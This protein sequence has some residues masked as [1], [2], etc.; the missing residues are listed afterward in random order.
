[1]TAQGHDIAH[2][3]SCIPAS[4]THPLRRLWPANSRG[5]KPAIVDR[6]WMIRLTVIGSIPEAVTSPP[7]VISGS[8]H[9]QMS[10]CP[11]ICVA[12]KI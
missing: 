6:F 8:A 5:S 4:V 2:G 10:N 9:P 12:R 3:L 7:L 11:D 1:M